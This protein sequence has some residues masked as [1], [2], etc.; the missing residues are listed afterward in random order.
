MEGT[1]PTET[2]LVLIFV[3][4]MFAAFAVTL[5]YGEFQTRN[6]KRPEEAISPELSGER[7]WRK[8]A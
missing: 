3:V 2:I 8:A 6:F 4:A 5:A 1:M 7:E